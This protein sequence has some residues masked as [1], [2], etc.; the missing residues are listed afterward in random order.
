MYCFSLGCDCENLPNAF[1]VEETLFFA[2]DLADQDWDDFT[3]LRGKF[4]RNSD[5]SNIGMCDSNSI[6][7][8]VAYY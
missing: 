1:Q 2:F 4:F 7:S 5:V 3:R 6:K 8:L